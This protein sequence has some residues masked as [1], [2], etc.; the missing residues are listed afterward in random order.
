MFRESLIETSRDTAARRG[1]ATFVSFC[2]ETAGIGVLVLVPLIYTDA[3][4]ALHLG[5]APVPPPRAPRAA[6]VEQGFTRVV[7]VPSEFQNGVLEAPRAIPTTTYVPKEPEVATPDFGNG[8]CP[9]CIPDGIPTSDERATTNV[10]ANLIKQPTVHT[11]LKVGAG[12]A[13]MVRVSRMDPGMLIARVEPHFPDL[14]RKTR[15][16]GQVVLAALIGRDGRIEGL[17]AV[18]GHPLL[19]KAAL[20]A[21]QQ[22]RYRPTLLNG[23]PVE[24]ETQI[25][26]N[27]YLN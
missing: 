2:L 9:G 6:D 19:V 10:I 13:K 24:V 18:S 11:V 5:E 12:Q 20:D 1:W 8:G 26:V 22:W 7:P 17:H 23:V 25:V 4:P 27:F 15:T 14:A 21:V 16:Q 3:L